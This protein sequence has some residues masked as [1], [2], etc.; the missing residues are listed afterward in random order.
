[1]LAKTEL[2]WCRLIH[3]NNYSNSSKE[4]LKRIESN[5]GIYLL[6]FFFCFFFSL[7][8]VL[9]I[10]FRSLFLKRLEYSLPF[11]YQ[12]HRLTTFKM[13]YC[14]LCVIL[15]TTIA[16]VSWFMIVISCFSRWKKKVRHLTASNA[17][18]ITFESKILLNY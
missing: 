14:S 11:W 17:V 15:L 1:M 18:M 2:N 8:F 10:T 16:I 6:R 4:Y 3:C 5:C 13:L 12:F 9:I 7:L